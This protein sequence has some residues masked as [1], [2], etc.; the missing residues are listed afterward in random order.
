M[1]G[2]GGCDLAPMQAELQLRHRAWLSSACS[3]VRHIRHPCGPRAQH[4]ARGKHCSCSSERRVTG[5]QCNKLSIAAG[6]AA[7]TSEQCTAGERSLQQTLQLKTLSD[8]RQVNGHFKAKLDP[9]GL[10]ARPVPLELDPALYG[11]SKED[12][13]RECALS[14]N[15]IM[16][17]RIAAYTVQRYALPPGLQRHS[18]EDLYGSGSL[19]ESYLPVGGVARKVVVVFCSRD[20]R[21][22]LFSTGLVAYAEGRAGMHSGGQEHCWQPLSSLAACKEALTAAHARFFLG[23]WNM[24]GFL[25]EERPIRTLREVL[26][27]LNDVYCST[28]G[29]EVRPAWRATPWR[30]TRA[31]SKKL[32]LCLVTQS[33]L[34]V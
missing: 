10:D 6:V 28:I 27:R 7:Q 20:L 21:S 34:D 14:P 19:Q 22:V 1:H 25:S 31:G 26:Q 24:K 9:L 18:E 15:D 3:R 32:M 23:T 16:H 13:D 4:S 29:Y 5:G 30:P 17:A 33:Y 8:A 11:F 2:V 12:V